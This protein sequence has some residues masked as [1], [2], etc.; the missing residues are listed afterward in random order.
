MPSRSKQEQR[1]VTVVRC[2]PTEH[3]AALCT[4]RAGPPSGN[5]T[6]RDASTLLG[7]QFASCCATA[8]YP[9]AA[10]SAMSTA[11]TQTS[12]PLSKFNLLQMPTPAL[13]PGHA[14]AC[15]AVP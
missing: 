1:H 6:C 5:P 4:C 10:A 12:A 7:V 15:R 8:A 13:E 3:A 2:T 9:D 14:L 11:D